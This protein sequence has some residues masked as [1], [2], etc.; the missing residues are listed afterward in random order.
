MCI[1]ISLN[2]RKCVFNSVY[3]LLEKGFV[4]LPKLYPEISASLHFFCEG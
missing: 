1:D 3:I 2:I 4:K